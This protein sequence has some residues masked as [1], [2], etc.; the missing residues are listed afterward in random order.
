MKKI[1][2]IVLFL[3]SLVTYGSSVAAFKNVKLGEDAPKFSLKELDSESTVSLDDYI[4]E[5]KV[6][7]LLFWATW[8]P[9][10]SEELE[11]LVKLRQDYLDKGVEVIAVNVEKEEPTPEE[12][13]KMAEMKETFN[14]D[15]KLLLDSGLSTFYEYGVIAVPSTIILDGAGAIKKIYDGYPTSARLDMKIDIEVMLGLREPEKDLEMVKDEGPKILKAAKLH[16]GLGRKLIERG[17][18]IKAVR[19]LEKSAKLDENYDLPLVLLG[20]LYEDEYLRV[21]S[22]SKKAKHL[23]N[24]ADAFTRALKRS[25]ENLFA[26]CGLVRVYAKMGKFPEADAAIKRALEL[27]SNFLTCLEA[28]G[29]LLQAKGQDE[30][31]II[32]FQRA[33]ELNKN[34][35]RV[36]YYL[37]KSYNNIKDYG[38]SISSLKESFRQLVT[39]IQLN[40]AQEK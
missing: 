28:K 22:K 12:L 2:S 37:A 16:Y 13:A 6:I 33:L 39:K 9:R 18:G 35:P 38:N 23:E 36:H 19:E 17:M 30:E 25:E 40:R 32:E 34:M 4:G 7:V 29:I 11:D 1:I 8:S 5:N 27:D 14:V 20:E 24:A 31:A 26:Q 3:A 10:S 21:R 15:F